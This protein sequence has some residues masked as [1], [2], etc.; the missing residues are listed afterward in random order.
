MA[1]NEQQFTIYE[2]LGKVF[3]EN[4]EGTTIE[5]GT[6]WQDERGRFSFRLN[7]DLAKGYG[8][9]SIEA[10]LRNLA[11]KLSLSYMQ[12]QFATASSRRTTTAMRRA[13]RLDINLAETPSR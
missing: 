2:H 3:A 4:H 11:D 1:T 10:A 7:G 12:S 5:L 9:A 8:F 13:S 6:L